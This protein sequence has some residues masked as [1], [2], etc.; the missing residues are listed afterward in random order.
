LEYFG[1]TLLISNTDDIAPVISHLKENL[2]ALLTPDVQIAH[3][4]KDNVG[5]KEISPHYPEEVW[6]DA[7]PREN[8]NWDKIYQALSA[9]CPQLQ[10]KIAIEYQ[11]PERPNDPYFMLVFDKN[12]ISLGD[13][14]LWEETLNIEIIETNYQ[15]PCN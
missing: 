8:K 12:G 6:F 10:G 3:W 9:I 15:L 7:I 4:H 5:F 14:S 11:H 2:A 13:D 1:F